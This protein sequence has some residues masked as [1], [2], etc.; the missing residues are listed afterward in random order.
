MNFKFVFIRNFRYKKIHSL[1][2]IWVRE[3]YVFLVDR[4]VKNYGDRDVKEC[5]DRNV[6]EC[7]EGFVLAGLNGHWFYIRIYKIWLGLNMDKIL[8][9]TRYEYRQN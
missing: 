5:E 6:K 7:G 9:C 8:V 2:Q 3:N 4:D 1:R